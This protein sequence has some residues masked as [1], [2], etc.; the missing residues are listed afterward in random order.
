MFTV[1]SFCTS[2]ENYKSEF[3]SD[4]GVEGLISNLVLQNVP[5]TLTDVNPIP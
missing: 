1:V 4:K 5:F 3:S 2:V